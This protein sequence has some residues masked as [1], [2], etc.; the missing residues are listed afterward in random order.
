MSEAL[1]ATPAQST[2][3][4]WHRM[5]YFRELPYDVALLLTVAGVAYT[6]FSRQPIAGYRE[7]LAPLIGIVFVGDG[8]HDANDKDEL[9][10]VGTQI[11]HWAA[12]LVAMNLVLLSRMQSM[13]NADTTGLVI[14]ILL[15][16]GRLWEISILG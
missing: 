2:P 4:I 1:P 7:L 8:W 12:F 14:L 6:S 10:L 3:R 5:S 11:L 13:L 15:V 16:L 9:G